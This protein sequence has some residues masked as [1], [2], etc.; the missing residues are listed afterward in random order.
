MTAP[1][2]RDQIKIKKLLEQLQIAS[3]FVANILSTHMALP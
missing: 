2:I 1:K 3:K